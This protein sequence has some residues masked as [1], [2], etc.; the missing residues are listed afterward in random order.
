MEA[1]AGRG[2]DARPA[3]R[4]IGGAAAVAA[5]EG[6]EAAAGED[7]ADEVEWEDIVFDVLPVRAGARKRSAGGSAQ[8]AGALVVLVR[9]RSISDPLIR[10]GGA[11]VVLVRTRS[12]TDPLITLIKALIGL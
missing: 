9:T 10:H 6:D 4:K 11:L 2:G 12:I 5:G 1:S 7:E 8:C 3:Q